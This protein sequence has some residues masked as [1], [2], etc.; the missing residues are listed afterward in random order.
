ML[1]AG[2]LMYRFRD[3]LLQVFLVHPGGPLWAK[4]DEGAWSIPKG[5]V[6]PDEDPLAA[7]RREFEEETGC[8][9]SGR[10]IP[11]TEVRL[12][13]GKVIRAWA[14]EGDC[15]PEGIRSNLFEMEWPPRSGRRQ[16]FPEVDRAGWFELEEARRKINPGQ[17]GLLEELIRVLSHT[18]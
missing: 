17:I 9:A 12:R 18:S 8:K 5:L 13:S 14:F 3:G 2:L 6:D 15:D 4:K 16:R 10:F 11:L 7:A 1:S